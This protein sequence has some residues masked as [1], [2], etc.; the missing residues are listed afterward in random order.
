MEIPADFQK[1]NPKWFEADDGTQV[2]LSVDPDHRPAARAH[3]AIELMGRSADVERRLGEAGIE[4]EVASAGST[5]ARSSATTRPAT[6]GN[7]ASESGPAPDAYRDRATRRT[8]RSIS[9]QTSSIG[10]W[11]CAARLIVP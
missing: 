10:M 2:H 7:C 3:T 9:G 5:R 6:V 8:M 4:F 11:P 1:Y